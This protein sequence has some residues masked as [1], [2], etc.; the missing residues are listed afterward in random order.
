[1]AKISPIHGQMSG[2]IGDNTWSHNKGGQYVRQRAIPTNPNSTKQQAVRAILATVSGQWAGLTASQ[3]AAWGDYAT[4][5]PVVDT[6]G[7]SI[8]LSG[9]AMYCALNARLI[10]AGA[11][12]VADPPV[13]VGPAELTGL[14]ITPTAP[15]SLSL[16][17]T[18][19]PLGA[20]E[21]VSFWMTLPSTA[22]RNPNINQARL[23]GYGPVAD[24]TPTVFVTPY[25]FASGHSFNCF[26]ARMDGAGRLSPLQK[27]RVTVP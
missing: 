2:S 15:N 21:R 3:Q 22:G 10:G 24:V 23:V 20:A 8:P 27:V 19:G 1:M 16:A 25:V 17:F 13:G 5:N 4:L 6:L 7:A 26:M 11:T 14:V 9:Q 12:A 18:G